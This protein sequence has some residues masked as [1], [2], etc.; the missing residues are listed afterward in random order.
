MNQNSRAFWQSFRDNTQ[1]LVV[2]PNRTLPQLEV[3]NNTNHSP[4]V[5][6]LGAGASLATCPNGDAF[7][8]RLPLMCNLVEVVG[9]GH[10]LKS[11]GVNDGFDD[12]EALY[13]RLSSDS[14]YSSLL[15]KVEQGVHNYFSEMRLPPEVT[16]YDKILLSLRSKDVIATF[17]WD[18]FLGEAIK[19]NR[20]I[21]DL[22]RILFLHGNV[23]VGVCIEHRLKGFLEHTCNVCKRPLSPTPLLFPVKQKNYASSPFISAEWEELKSY[24]EYA[25]V[26]TVFGYSA[27][28]ADQEAKKLLLDAWQN[29]S[30]NELAE[31]EIID[32]RPRDEIVRN[33]SPFLVRQHYSVFDDVNKSLSFTH[34]RRSCEAFAMATLQQ[35]PWKENRYPAAQDLREIK[36]WM[37]PLLDEERAGNLSGRPCS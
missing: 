25:Y 16:I 1:I 32:I 4:H 36:K 26:V 5:V 27:P 24:M 29:N 22:P 30:T 37:Q 7:G 14:R 35:H 10:L 15:S 3:A 9:L 6:I 23:D 31:I 21:S 28:V 8:R 34:V 18:P 19:R 20:D 33:W 17:N 11:H 13:D 12:F 2:M